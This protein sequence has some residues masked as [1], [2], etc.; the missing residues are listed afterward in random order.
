M[1]FEHPS[2]RRIQMDVDNRKTES[3]AELK[4]LKEMDIDIEVSLL[5]Q[6]RVRHSILIDSIGGLE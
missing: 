2:S 1:Y 6:T 4:Q 5:P 3:R